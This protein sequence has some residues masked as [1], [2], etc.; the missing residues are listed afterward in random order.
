MKLTWDNTQQAIDEDWTTTLISLIQPNIDIFSQASDIEKFRSNFHTLNDTQKTY[1]IAQLFASDAL[2]ES[3]WNPSEK[4]VD[5]GSQ[6]DHNTWSV[7]LWQM[8]VCD[9]DNYGLPFQFTFDDLCMMKPNAQ[10]AVNVMLAQIQKHGKILIP[11]GEPGVYWSTLCPMGR[12]DKSPAIIEDCQN[13][14]FI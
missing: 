14:E 6:N 2:Y 1:V 10:L 13:M 11:H 4:D 9:Q 8:S 5:V 3:S 7:G 12:Y